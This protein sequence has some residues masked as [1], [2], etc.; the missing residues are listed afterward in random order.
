MIH[1]VV[2]LVELIGMV[3]RGRKA[4]HSTHLLVGLIWQLWAQHSPLVRM[5]LWSVQHTPAGGHGLAV[6]GAV[7][8][9][10]CAYFLNGGRGSRLLMRLLYQ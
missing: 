5:L 6:V 1:C 7:Q 8:D 9:S 10:W 3:L 4:W 2:H